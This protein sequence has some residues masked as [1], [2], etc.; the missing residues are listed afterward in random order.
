MTASTAPTSATSSSF[1][2]ISR[3][4]PETGAG[5]SVST[6]SVETS[7]RASSASIVS[8]TSFSQRLMVPSVTDSPRAGSVT[9]VPSVAPGSTDDVSA[10]AFSGTSAT[11]ASAAGAGCSASTGCSVEGAAGAGTSA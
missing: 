7:T 11:G 2:R 6:L 8:P 1:T 9:S 4:V 5:I 10:G 3:I